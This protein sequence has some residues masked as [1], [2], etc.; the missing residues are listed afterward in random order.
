MI[1]GAKFFSLDALPVRMKKL[2]DNI[3]HLYHAGCRTAVNN[4]LVGHKVGGIHVQFGADEYDQIVITFINQFG[5]E[6]DKIVIRARKLAK[7]VDSINEAYVILTNKGFTTMSKK[8]KKTVAETTVVSNEVSNATTVVSDNCSDSAEVDMLTEFILQHYARSGSLFEL[9]EFVDV[10]R[11]CLAK[12]CGAVSNV[13]F[14]GDNIAIESA[15]KVCIS[16]N[17]ADMDKSV[18]REQVIWALQ[19]VVERNK[20]LPDQKACSTECLELAIEDKEKANI[21]GATKVKPFK[22]KVSEKAVERFNEAVGKGVDALE[23]ILKGLSPSASSQSIRCYLKKSAYNSR[24]RLPDTSGETLA[25]NLS[26]YNVELLHTLCASANC[27]IPPFL[28]N[29]DAAVASGSKSV[30][31]A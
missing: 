18:L 2:G 19:T 22:G 24:L 15:D 4:E 27:K 25:K 7:V 21:K 30:I 13:V 12:S 28:Q 5:A 17:V 11:L 8:E 1:M 16:F 26:Q 3:E 20:Q 6:S 14:N 23:P 9:E 29:K 10:S 31:R